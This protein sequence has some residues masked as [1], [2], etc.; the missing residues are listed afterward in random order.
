MQAPQVTW[1]GGKNTYSEFGV[2]LG[3][4]EQIREGIDLGFRPRCTGM[5]FLS[6][7]TRRL[8]SPVRMKGAISMSVLSSR[9]RQ[10]HCRCCSPHPGRHPATQIWPPTPALGHTEI[11]NSKSRAGRF[12]SA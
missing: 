3:F 1:M 2:L 6:R 12:L 5:S 9:L 11:G 7:L 10:L 8:K 4:D